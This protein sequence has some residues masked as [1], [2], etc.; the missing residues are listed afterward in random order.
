MAVSSNNHNTDNSTAQA[1]PVPRAPTN[2]VAP[3]YDN[4][5]GIN[6]DGAASNDMA[7][8]ANTGR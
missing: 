3:S 7:T 5:N 4:K 6:G 8:S 2:N 1:H